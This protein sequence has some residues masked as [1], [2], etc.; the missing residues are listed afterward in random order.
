M[1][2]FR[3]TIGGIS[4]MGGLRLTS[5]ILILLRTIILARLLS[6]LQFGIFGIV[7]LAISLFE[8]FTETGINTVLI[9]EDEKIEPLINTAWVVSIIRGFLIFLLLAIFAWPLASFFASPAATKFLFLAALIPLVKGFINPA[10]IKFQKELEFNKEFNLRLAILIAESATAVALAFLTRSVL[11]LILGL[12]VG[13]ILEVFLSFKFC[14][15]RPKLALE[16]EKFAKIFGRGKWI[17]LGGIFSCLV[18]QGDDAVVG[19][20]LGV[21]TLGLYQMAYKISNLPFTEI[22]SVFYTVTFPVYAKINQDKNEVWRSFKKMLGLTILLVLPLAA[23]IFFFP[24]PII[25]IVLGKQWLG[26]KDALR[27][28][29][30]FGLTRAIGGTAGPI[31]FAFKRQ[32]LTARIEL[33]KLVFLAIL[34]V[35]L[36]KLYGLAGASLAVLLSSLLLQPVIFY[37]VRKIFR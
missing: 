37:Q 31:F 19:R 12:L 14:F 15:P 2:A 1:G 34:I 35:P 8:I 36:T 23:V 7:T 29:A 11:S 26:A 16:K 21:S 3:Q 10:I 28:L 24:E 17:T 13:G 25:S 32:D 5:R 30:V 4:W 27:I 9:Q 18:D 6:P 20:L 33:A 22:T